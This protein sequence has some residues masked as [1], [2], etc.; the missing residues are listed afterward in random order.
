VWD[1]FGEFGQ[2]YRETQPRQGDLQTVLA[3]LLSGQYERPLSIVVTAEAWAR[4]VIADMAH[5][6][7][8]IDPLPNGIRSL[9]SGPL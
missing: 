4:D 7:E 1:D 8:R 3:D 6:D 9:H 2:A 5:Q